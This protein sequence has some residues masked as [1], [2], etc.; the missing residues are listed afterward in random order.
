M[1][2]FE[3]FPGVSHLLKKQAFPV[4]FSDGTLSEAFGELIDSYPHLEDDLMD[5]KVLKLTL[6]TFVND[7]RIPNTVHDR[8]EIRDG[9][10][11]TVL[12]PISGG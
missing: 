5:D 8:H 2:T 3:L 6:A 10:K 11:I 7:E 9:D 12:S 1:I 4:D